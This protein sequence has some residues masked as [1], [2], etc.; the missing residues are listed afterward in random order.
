MTLLQKYSP[1]LGDEQQFRRCPESVYRFS[2]AHFKSSQVS[3]NYSKEEEASKVTVKA[4][5]PLRKELTSNVEDALPLSQELRLNVEDALRQKRDKNDKYT[6]IL[7]EIAV[8]FVETLSIFPLTTSNDY[9]GKCTSF[10]GV[11]LIYYIGETSPY[12]NFSSCRNQPI[13]VG[14][15][16]KNI[17]DQL[18]DH[19]RNVARA[20][21]LDVT[22]FDVRFMIVDI[23]YYVSSIEKTLIEYYDPL[24][25]NKRVRFYFGDASDEDNNWYKY[26]VDKNKDVRKKMIKR[27]EEYQCNKISKAEP[28]LN[29]PTTPL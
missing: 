19:C 23:E 18:N 2:G 28:A 7:Q 25:N 17:L 14:K 1:E 29:L 5:L 4:A 12:E 24:W 21:D 16:G 15:S 27:V 10:P 9:L 26:H 13:Y 8:E 3:T 6:C 11:Y 20:M 22:D